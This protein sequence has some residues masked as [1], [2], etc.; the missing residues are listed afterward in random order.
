MSP[1]RVLIT[2]V[3]GVVGRALARQLVREGVSVTGAVRALPPQ[4]DC[5]AGVDYSVVGDIGPNTDWTEA[6]RGVDQVVHAAA[7]TGDQ[8]PVLLQR[9]NAQGTDRLAQV[10]ANRVSTMVLVSSLGVHGR[11]KGEGAVRTADLPRP[12]DA[13]S[14]SKLAAEQAMRERLARTQTAWVIVRPP[15]IYGEGCRGTPRRLQTAVRRGWPLP[16]GSIV[17]RRSLISADNLADFVRLALLDFRAL[18]NTWLIADR[19]DFS[20]PDLLR[21]VAEAEGI[22]L[23]IPRCPIFLLRAL[24]SLAGRGRDVARLTESLYIDR[25]EVTELL[26]WVPPRSTFDDWRHTMLAGA[27]HVR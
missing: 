22:S 15:M 21:L 24:G 17:N 27:V 26:G 16:L 8:A 18:R 3:T 1:R 13:Y 9:V 23:R 12:H 5:L 7:L 10:A 19:E 14:Q 2:G 25:S 20:T 4:A 6:L 11:S